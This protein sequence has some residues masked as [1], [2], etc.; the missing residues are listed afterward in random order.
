MDPPPLLL[1]V[2]CPITARA[3][4]IGSNPGCVQNLSS[5]IATVAFIR[6]FAISS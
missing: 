3:I 5:S 6:Y 1:W 4:P 2:I